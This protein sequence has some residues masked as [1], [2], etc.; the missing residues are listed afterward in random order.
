[1][2]TKKRSYPLTTDL[3]T[4]FSREM[5]DFVPIV[6][7]KGHGTFFFIEYLLGIRSIFIGGKKKKLGIPCT[8]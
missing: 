7:T 6:A 2:Q 3:S 8:K 5:S 1:M 4:K